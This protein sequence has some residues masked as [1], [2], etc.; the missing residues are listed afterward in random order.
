MGSVPYEAD[1]CMDKHGALETEGDSGGGHMQVQR[2]VSIREHWGEGKWVHDYKIGQKSHQ[3]VKGRG[4]KSN[5]G[6]PPLGLHRELCR[7][8]KATYRKKKK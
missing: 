5:K 8:R 6:A 1:P 2:E 7:L 4:R 3:M